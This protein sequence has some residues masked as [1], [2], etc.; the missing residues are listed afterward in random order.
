MQ[1]KCQACEK[2]L[3]YIEKV[4]ASHQRLD[5]ELYQVYTIRGALRALW[6]AI[7]RKLTGSRQNS[8]FG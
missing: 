5:C 6:I 8:I 7:V 2:K 3:D 4:V 1:E